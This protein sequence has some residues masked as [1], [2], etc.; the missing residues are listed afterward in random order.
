M[1]A[2]RRNGNSRILVCSTVAPLS[3]PPANPQSQI[4]AL[5]LLNLNALE[6]RLEV[7]HAEA[8]RAAPLDDLEEHRRAVLNGARENLEQVAL[9]V[10]VG[11]DAE[12]GDVLVFLLDLADARGQGVVIR[13]R[14]AQDLQPALPQLAP[15]ADGVARDQRDV[16]DAGA[17]VV[18]QILLDLAL[19]LA[20]GRLVDRELDAPVAV[21]HHLR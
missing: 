7:P 3:P 19:L 10:A 20:L 15:R 8:A 6:Q 4:A 9:V 12:V 16:L 17:E 1:P 11:E 18:I 13:L 14:H 5:R 2:I 21:A